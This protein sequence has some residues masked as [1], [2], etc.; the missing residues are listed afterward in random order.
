MKLQ[1]LI[2]G[3][4]AACALVLTL[5]SCN[6]VQPGVVE[7]GKLKLS[8]EEDRLSAD[9]F[10][11]TLPEPGKEIFLVVTDLGTCL[12]CKKAAIAVSN[13]WQDKGRPETLVF[14]ETLRSEFDR[15]ASADFIKEKKLRGLHYLCDAD[16]VEKVT[17]MLGEQP[18]PP[19][20]YFVGAK[21]L[22]HWKGGYLASYASVLKAIRKGKY[23]VPL[24]V[25]TE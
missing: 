18:V 25:K 21:G 9:Q 10:T 2:R 3:L 17:P 1:A 13:S 8:E 19:A 5:G 24:G 22:I 11:T 14:L 4:I 20:H 6:R 16:C 7:L 23:D 12:E 15:Q